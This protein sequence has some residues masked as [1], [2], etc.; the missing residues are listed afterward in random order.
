MP[1]D[2][3]FTGIAVAIVRDKQ[4]DHWW[5]ALTK[6]VISPYIKAMGFAAAAIGNAQLE[7]IT[8]QLQIINIET[9]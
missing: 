9:V 1:L 5:L 3:C 8:F 6:H 2:P 7:Q 4:L